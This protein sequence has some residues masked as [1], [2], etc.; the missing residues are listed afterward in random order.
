MFLEDYRAGGNRFFLALLSYASVLVYHTH[1]FLYTKEFAGRDL[2][3]AF[4]LVKS[5]GFGWSQQWFLG[6]PK[7]HFYPPGFFALADSV[8][9]LI[10]DLLAFKLLIYLA[11]LVFP[12]AVYYCFY[13]LFDVKVGLVALVLTFPAVFLREPVSLLYQTLQVGLV[14]QMASLPFL[15]LYIGLLWT[16]NRDSLYF[17]PLAVAAMILLHPYVALVAGLYTVIYGFLKQ[18]FFRPAVS[19]LGLALTAWWWIPILE[20]SWY[21]QVYT[22]PSGELL[23]WPWIFLP[24]LFADRSRKALSLSV[25]AVSLLIIGTFDFGLG[26]Q[27]YRFYSY[28]YLTTIIAA[29]PGLSSVFDMIGDRVEFDTLLSLLFITFLASTTVIA[30]DVAPEWRSDVET[31]GVVPEE[32]RMIVETSHSDLYNSYVPIQGIPLES[33]VTVVNGLYAD[34]S[35]SSPYLIGLEKA[36]AKDPV[37]NPIAVE[38]NLSSNQLEERFKYFGIEYALVRTQ[39]AREKLGFMREVDSNDDFMLLGLEN[40]SQNSSVSAIPVKGSYEEWE[41]LSREVFR[42]DLRYLYYV[43]NDSKAYKLG[44]DSLNSSGISRVRIKVKTES[45]RPENRRQALFGLR[46]DFSRKD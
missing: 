46:I 36:F 11:L 17:I 3:G 7:F 8:G 27:S 10:G 30:G 28:G 6:F 45:I 26:L 4:S 38:A 19:S 22:G 33:N 18:D 24:L 2:I 9:Y 43:P 20:K 15:F 40:V 23:N 25:L 29:A 31:E 12:V 35:I 39:H 37:P 41:G 5:F 34:S 1:S 16:D 13:S 32:G 21:M 42:N 14:A 44:E